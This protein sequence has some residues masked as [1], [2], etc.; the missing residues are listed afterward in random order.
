MEIEM[1]NKPTPLEIRCAIVD[2]IVA[3]NEAARTDMEM[4][5]IS[6]I[7]YLHRLFPVG[8]HEVIRDA[9]T[10]AYEAKNAD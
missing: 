6:E 5:R 3:H 1:Q 2:A 7:A 8:A 9:I 4:G 10:A